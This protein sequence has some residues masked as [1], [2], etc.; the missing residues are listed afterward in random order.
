MG[1]EGLTVFSASIRRPLMGLQGLWAA[2]CSLSLY[3]A[4]GGIWHLVPHLE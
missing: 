2:L 3:F 4:S 1:G